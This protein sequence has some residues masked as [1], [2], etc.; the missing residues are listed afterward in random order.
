[1]KVKIKSISGKLPEQATMGSACVDLRACFE[2]VDDINKVL[3]FN[4]LLQNEDGTKALRSIILNPGGRVLVPT[5]LFLAIP[6]GYECVIRPRSGLA[7]KHGISMVNSPGTIDSD[8]RNEIGIILIN[9]GH[10]PFLINDGDRVAQMGL[11]ETIVID[12]VDVKE[13]DST[14][15]GQGG[16]G[17]TGVK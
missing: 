11:R 14:E 3:G 4:V 1:M 2:H 6:D 5:G 13:L 8:Y 9:N 15:R 12:W 10:E 17:H 7:L 16:L